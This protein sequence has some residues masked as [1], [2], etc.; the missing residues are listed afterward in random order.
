[1]RLSVERH[2]ARLSAEL[3]KSRIRRG[4]ASIQDL[5]AHVDAKSIQIED[6]SN[7]ISANDGSDLHSTKEP[8]LHP[9][10][11]R[12]N[13]I[14]TDL[15]EQ[16][17]TTFAGYKIIDSIDELT[18]NSSHPTEELIHIDKHVPNLVALSSTIDLSKT[19]AYRNGLI[20][21]Q[22]KAS[23]FP[24]YLLDPKPQ[25][26]HVL[27]ACA[28][29][30]NKTTH[31]AAILREKGNTAQ[32]LDIYACERD[33]TR[34]E[35]LRQM[36]Q[37]AGASRHVTIKGG[38]DFLRTPTILVPW[39]K[40]RSLLLDPSCSGSGILS[41]EET[42][43]VVLP[44]KLAVELSK[45][46]SKKRKRAEVSKETQEVKEIQEEIPIA[47]SKASYQLSERLSAL[48][49]FQLNLLEHAFR[50]PSAS[51][52]TYSTCSIYAEE[53]EHVVVKALNS[54]IAKK[55]GW[56]ILPRQSQISGMREWAIRGVLQA[57]KACNEASAI[58]DVEEVA[59]ACI[60]CEKGTKE[61]TQG[62]FVAA[63]VRDL[64]NTITEQSVEEEW[65]GFSDS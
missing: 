55:R 1:M 10:W 37:V 19:S 64:E 20:I 17:K 44:G 7:K 63:F 32:D 65:E 18:K 28:A 48:S 29:P 34:A 49:T 15:S 9:R 61:G 45:N 56:R 6:E 16:M 12:I 13:T 33:K 53:N 39:N 23:C 30:G 8:F 36:I 42:F 62:F 51:R 47:E 41:R 58:V 54:R 21:L 59:E 3:T 52:I 40:I 11:V 27:D 22:D 26:G 14:K 24:A 25:D 50:F 31:L 4:H 38:Q 2:K 43:K 57:C 5:R 60:R 46:S 35:T